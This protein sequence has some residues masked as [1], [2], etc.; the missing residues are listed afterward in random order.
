MTGAPRARNGFSLRRGNREL[1]GSWCGCLPIRANLARDR[2]QV[3]AQ[4]LGRWAAPKPVAV[5]RV[6]DREVRE[7]REHGGHVRS[8]D[9]VGRLAQ[10]ELFEQLPRIVGEE[11]PARAESGTESG[12]DRPGID[13]DGEE[14]AVRDLSLALKMDQP[15]E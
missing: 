12:G 3:L 8:V 1:R 4:L 15:A 5:V 7:E 2:A 11:G 6:V 13:A 14:T 9:S 10:A